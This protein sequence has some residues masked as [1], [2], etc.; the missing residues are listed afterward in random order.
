MREI[1][2]Q[3]MASLKTGSLRSIDLKLGPF[4]TIRNVENVTVEQTCI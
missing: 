1:S 3:K 4:D 2:T